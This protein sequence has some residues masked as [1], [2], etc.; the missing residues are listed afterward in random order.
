MKIL[1]STPFDYAY[2]GGVNAHVESLDRELRA[3][4]HETRILTPGAQNG[5]AEYDGRICRIGRAIPIHA[6]GSIARLALS[7]LLGDRVRA[8]LEGERFDIVHLNDPLTS[9][10]HL[11]VLANSRAINVGTFHASNSSYLG[12]NL[13]YRLGRPIFDWYSQRIDYRIAVSPVARDF[14]SHY[15]DGDY[16]LI[17]NGIDFDEFGPHVRPDPR[18]HGAAPTVLFVGRF[19]EPR[20]GLRYL[21][22]AMRGVQDAIPNARLVVVGPG[23][24]S[25]YARR[26]SRLGLRNVLFMGETPRE[27]LPGLYAACDVFCAPSTGRESFGIV[28]LEAMASGKPVVASD[29]S[30]YRSVVRNGREALLTPPGDTASLTCAILNVL[31]NPDLAR[32]LEMAGRARAKSCSWPTIARRVV[33]CY[34]KA[35]QPVRRSRPSLATTP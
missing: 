34:E 15:F 5:H 2:P 31:T 23:D 25:V 12:F 4:G 22:R 14:I 28:L 9:T 33:E 18:V 20:K 24:A 11:S 3:L 26:A 27:A 30:G 1:L 17:P 35:S 29:I 8:F 10:L 19:D 13:L 32:R 16:D 7:P 6:N 21:I